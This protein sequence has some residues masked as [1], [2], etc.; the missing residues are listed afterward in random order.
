MKETW[1]FAVMMVLLVVL[2]TLVSSS[3]P[4]GAFVANL[5]PSWDYTTDEF[6]SPVTIDLNRAFFD[7][8]RD[9]LA[10]SV[11]TEGGVNAELSGD[12]VVLEGAGDAVLSA[13]DGKVLVSKR[14]KIN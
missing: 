7:A 11:V 4:T 2:T 5:P 9:S 8:D 1:P 13:S 6:E 14:V 3:K 10:F 12:V